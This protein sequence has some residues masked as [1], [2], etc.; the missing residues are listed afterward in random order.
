[1]A[2]KIPDYISKQLQI[3]GLEGLEKASTVADRKRTTYEE[4]LKALQSRILTL[5]LEVSLLWIL[6]EKG[7]QNES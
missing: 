7:G 3:P 6:V 5:E 1:M 2:Q 4:Q